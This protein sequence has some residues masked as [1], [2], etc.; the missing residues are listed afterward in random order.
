MPAPRPGGPSSTPRNSQGMR[1]FYKW[2][3]PG[4]IEAALLADGVSPDKLYP[5]DLDR[6]FKKLDTINPTSSG[7]QAARSRNSSSL[8]RTPFG[9][10]WNGRN[11]GARASGIN[12]ETSWEQNI[13]RRAAL[14][15][16]KGSKNKEAAMQFH[17]ARHI[18]EAQADLA[19][20]TGYAPINLDSPKMMDPEFG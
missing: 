6:A 7:G 18:A 5:L 17:S 20:I 14:V 3:A 13:N 12:V 19:K 2:S 8:R 15:V 10:V 1:A 9:S 11:D 4:V 16:P